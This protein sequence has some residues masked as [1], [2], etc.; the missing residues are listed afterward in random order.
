MVKIFAE[1]LKAVR[2]EKNLSL[3]TIAQQTRLNMTVLENIENGDFT[4]QPQAYIRAF[5]KQYINSLGL[6]VEE[7]LFDYDLAK[8]G[9][10]KSKRQNL[11]ASPKETSIKKETAQLED[12]KSKSSE[13]PAELNET[14]QKTN[15]EKRI[16]KAVEKEEKI[17]PDEPAEKK[18]G[19]KFTLK[20]PD[21]NRNNYKN[22]IAGK[23]NLTASFLNSPV[24]RNIALILFIALVLLG[25]YSLINILFFDSSKDNPEVIRQNFDDVVKEQ[26]KKILGKRT[27]EEIKDSIRKAEQDFAASA[28]SITLKIT[29]LNI[30]TLFLVTDSVNYNRPEKIEFEKNEVGIFKARKS[31][32]ISGNT[33]TFRATINDRPIKFDKTSISKAKLTKEGLTK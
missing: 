23:K 2:E 29:A 7:T 33:E 10:Y 15:E 30:G 11:A 31:F 28:D 14:S 3:R 1:D 20:P 32:Y 13:I 6:D 27:S 24:I 21:E 16:E 18:F 12:D 8:S 19:S 22:E 9:K 26:E 5:L 25:I 4:F 17:I